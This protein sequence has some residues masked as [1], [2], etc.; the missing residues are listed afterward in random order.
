ML[1]SF[2]C[3]APVHDNASTVRCANHPELIRLMGYDAPAMP[4]SCQ[5]GDTCPEGDPF[6]ARDA[7]RAI[8][9]GRPLQCETAGIDNQERTLA[10]CRV[11]GT[12]LSAAML[13]TGHAV[14]SKTAGD[15]N[16]STPVRRRAVLLQSARYEPGALRPVPAVTLDIG[17]PRIAATPTAITMG[18][19]PMRETPWSL[20]VAGAMVMIG[21]WMAMANLALL[22]LAHERWPARHR[23]GAPMD[24]LDPWLFL[25]LAAA[26]ATPAAWTALWTRHAGRQQ[27]QLLPRLLNITGIQI[28]L[29]VG[30]LWWWIAG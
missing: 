26:G 25:G 30:A 17:E 10:R 3:L 13:A 5:S 14:P 11:D 18:S 7:L 19:T 9:L 15:C 29:L 16:C 22:Q 20:P 12:D 28:G 24:R 8:S 21:L 23:W 27:D 4:A 6:A 2:T 1:G